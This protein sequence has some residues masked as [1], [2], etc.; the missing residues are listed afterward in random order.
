[1]CLAAGTA[2]KLTLDLFLFKAKRILVT[3]FRWSRIGT[4]EQ[5]RSSSLL[6][7][8]C[9]H[10]NSICAGAGERRSPVRGRGEDN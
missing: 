3:D 6:F 10:G 2:G 8:Y 5:S 1:M 4:R 7:A 9:S